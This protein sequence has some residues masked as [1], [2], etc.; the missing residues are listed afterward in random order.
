M[1]PNK[2]QKAKNKWKRWSREEDNFLRQ[3]YAFLT[4]E[5]ISKI[6]CR[7]MWSIDYRAGHI[8]KIDRR[9]TR[10][11]REGERVSKIL[12]EMSPEEIGYL[13]GLVD[14]EGCI[15]VICLEKG[16]RGLIICPKIEISN[17]N[18]GIVS[19]LKSIGLFKE[20]WRHYAERCKPCYD[21]YSYGYK[22]LPILEQIKPHLKGKKQQA[23][24]L[25][26]YIKLRMSRSMKNR[27]YAKDE[28]GLIKKLLELNRRGVTP[29]TTQKAL[30]KLQ[31]YEKLLGENDGMDTKTTP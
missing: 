6:L 27:P 18:S 28:I 9:R 5:Q 14:G 10:V 30:R 19:W 16:R 25:S 4:S 8:L 3:N 23:E 17:T 2:I 24:I 12:G 11:K 15:T 21:L 31:E 1:Y 7:T 13:A 29:L 26:S 20:G 22:I